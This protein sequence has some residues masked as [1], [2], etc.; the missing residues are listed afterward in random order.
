MT[1]ANDKHQ[2]KLLAAGWHSRGYLPHFDGIAIPQ[3]V[4]ID[5]VRNQATG[6]IAVPGLRK[7]DSKDFVVQEKK[8]ASI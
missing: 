4:T 1:L 7:S 3:F 5:Y 8:V 6:L 2:E